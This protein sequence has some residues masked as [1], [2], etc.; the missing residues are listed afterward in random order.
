MI[1]DAHCHAW[2]LWPYEPPAPDPNS[3]SV[4]EQLLFEMDQCGIAQAVLVAARI[5][6]NRDNNDY[7]A[8]CVRRFPERLYQFADVDCMWTPTYHAP[9]AADRLAEAVHTYHLRGFTHYV[10]AADDGSWFFSVDGQAFLSTAARLNQV[11]SIHLPVHLQPALRRL[12]EQ[13][14]G[15]PFVCHHMGYPLTTEGPNGGALTEILAS[16]AQPNIHIKLSG[17]HYAAPT[18]W[19]YPHTASGYI[20]RALY[21]HFGPE[22]LHWGSDYPVVRWAMTY[23]QSLE[24]IRTH[25]ADSMSAADMERVLGSSLH[26][27]LQQHGTTQ[28]DQSVR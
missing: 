18:G 12:A 7:V 3:R 21:D 19:E 11:V 15:T 5:D 24:V 16:A 2:R 23:R 17:F 28:T 22:R 20:V 26:D 10:A 4:V 14:P 13:F 25:C 6:H 1:V 9:G 8:E 27:L